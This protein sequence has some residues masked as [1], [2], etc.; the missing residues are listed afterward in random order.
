MENYYKDRIRLEEKRIDDLKE[1][2]E[3]IQGQIQSCK[4]NIQR[5]RDLIS[6]NQSTQNKRG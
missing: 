5:Y 2:K 1:K 4:E 3:Q 6:S